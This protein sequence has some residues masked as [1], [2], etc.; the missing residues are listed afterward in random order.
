ME[1][2]RVIDELNNGEPISDMASEL[3][4]SVKLL[5]TKLK[6]AAVS[7][8][9]DAKVWKYNGSNKEISLSR[10]ITKTI[11]LL[12]VDKPFVNRNATN[13]K[14]SSASYD[15][16]YKLYKDYLAVN[17][18]KIETKKT[19]FFSDDN[20]DTIKN[21]SK[22]RSLKISVLIHVLIMKGLEYYNLDNDE[23][24]N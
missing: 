16:D 4:I 9:S 11:K 22:E 1:I 18:E 6:N 24:I 2:I 17:Q 3:G 14:K 13:N 12:G 21:I 8:D 23:I 10:D 7:F 5:K 20:Y 15:S 19:I